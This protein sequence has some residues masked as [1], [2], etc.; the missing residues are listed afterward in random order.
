LFIIKADGFHISS[1]GD[2]RFF[3]LGYSYPQPKLKAMISN[4]L[5]MSSHLPLDVT[6]HEDESKVRSM[7]AGRMVGV[8]VDDTGMAYSWGIGLSGELGLSDFSIAK[9]QDA[10]L[11]TNE[12][13]EKMRGAY[14]DY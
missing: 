13:E 6:L 7:D 2:N 11:E 3:Q 8:Y 12:E 1:I 9:Q 4:R 14:F 10:V 5:E